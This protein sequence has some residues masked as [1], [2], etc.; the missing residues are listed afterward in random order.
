M[1]KEQSLNLPLKL[2]KMKKT[3]KT[4]ANRSTTTSR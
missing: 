4:V 1:V 3:Q 2:V